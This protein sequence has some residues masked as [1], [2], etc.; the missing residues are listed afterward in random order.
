MKLLLHV[1][2]GPCS[3]YPL[4]VLKEEGHDIRGYF[5]NP[6]I[7]PYTEFKKRLDTF[8][9]YAEKIQLPVIIDDNYEVEKYLRNI[10]FR[11]GDRC[12]I[13][14]SIRLRRAAQIARK[15]NFEGFTTTLLVSPF[16]KH[17]L[18]KDIGDAV[19]KEMGVPF[20]YWDFRT[21]YKEGVQISKEEKM[22]RQQYCGCIY[23]EWDRYKPRSKKK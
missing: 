20:Y 13:C 3:T 5:Y 21:G 18:I 12:R 8:T 4:K 15:G 6:N 9:D 19:G 14:Y 11:E 17:E 10:V 2:C 22:Y 16:Q 1:C 7:H 23:S